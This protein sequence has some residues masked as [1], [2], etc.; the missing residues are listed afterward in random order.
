MPSLQFCTLPPPTT[1]NTYV[2][3]LRKIYL[4]VWLTD[5]IIHVGF[6]V[7]MMVTIEIT[8]FWDL[9]MSSLPNYMA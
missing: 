6:E 1:Q 4:L 9:T 2:F 5:D 7:L 8:A 3:L